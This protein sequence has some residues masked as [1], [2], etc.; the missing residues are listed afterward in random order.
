MQQNEYYKLYGIHSNIPECCVDAFING[1]KGKDT[2]VSWGY[3][4][5]D[6]CEQTN[7]KVKIHICDMSCEPFMREI[8]ELPFERIFNIFLD[9]VFLGE[10]I[11]PNGL[12]V[13]PTRA[14]ILTKPVKK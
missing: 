9:K 11:L 6:T 1:K 8:L 14:F 5:C 3:I 2:K 7:N 4:P 12:V 10:L 13:I